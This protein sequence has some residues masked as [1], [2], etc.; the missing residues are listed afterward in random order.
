[1]EVVHLSCLL[2]GQV[3]ASD[4]R[5]VGKLTD[6]IVRLGDG[7]YPPLTGLVLDVAGRERFAH[8]SDVSG[9]D[10]GAVRLSRDPGR[11]GPFER[12][13]GEVLLAKDVAGRH[14]IHLKGARLVR[15]NEIELACVNGR[16]VVVGADPTSRPV[17]RRLLPRSA[18]GRVEAGGVVDW[19]EIEP[20]VAHV[21]T[22]RLRIALRKLSRLHPAQLADLVEAASHEEG[23]EI[24]AAV[25]ADR[26]LEAD[27]FEELDLEHQVEFLRSRSDEEAAR[28]LA[29]MAPDD[30]VDL[31]EELDQER[32]L[33]ILQRLPAAHQ[34]KL[35]SL[36][37]YNPE[38]AGGLMNPDFV[39]VPGTVSAGEALAAVKSS[40]VAP[41]ASGVVLVTDDAGRLSGT[42]GVVELLRADPGAPVGTVAHGDPV[43]LSPDADV[44]EVSRVMS[45]YNLAVLPVLDGQRRVL[46]LISVDDVL[47]LLLP[48][49]WR[50]QYGMSSGA[51]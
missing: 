44:H 11:L 34:R 6:V 10:T 20:F 25:G 24:I 16:W 4:G 37:S 5:R 48:E 1:M 9:L 26:E 46:G 42:V 39:A 13:P 47:E 32:R 7:G 33:P 28:V 15:A 2:G 3:M 43:A 31:L 41:E 51:G 14:L 29:A 36:L 49:G 30:A 40:T 19:A 8:M 23:E 35:R 50:R 45:D 12:R 18:R 27:L 17:V 38:T 21:P 22:A